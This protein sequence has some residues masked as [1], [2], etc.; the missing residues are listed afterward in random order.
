M[1]IRGLLHKKKWLTIGGNANAFFS[2]PSPGL[3][4]I[5]HE[6]CDRFKN[7]N[8]A[9]SVIFDPPRASWA[10][11]NRGFYPREASLASLVFVLP[12]SRASISCSQTD[13]VSSQQLAAGERGSAPC[14]LM[15]S[16]GKMHLFFWSLLPCS[17]LRFWDLF[18]AKKNHRAILHEQVH[19]ADL[20]ST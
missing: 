17:S 10:Q 14:C 16:L 9:K 20:T 13:S 6:M 11:I 4:K 2:P 3:S 8:I 1:A 7:E 19:C 5:Q 15:T 18:P 12:D